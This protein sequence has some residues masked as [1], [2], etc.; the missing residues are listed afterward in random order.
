MRTVIIGGTGTLGK[1][2][3]RQLIKKSKEPV[4]IFSRDELKQKEMASEF[5]SDQVSYVLGDV[6]DRKA[7]SRVFRENDTVFHVAAIKHVDTCELNPEECI[8]TNVFGTVNV[9]D[10]AMEKHVAYV[11]FSS[12]DKAVDPINIY[13]MCKGISEKILLNRNTQGK[14][15]FS[16]FRWGNVLGSRGSVIAPFIDSLISKSTV[17][18]THA[19][20]TRFWIPIDQA[21]KFMLEQYKSAPAD[22]VLIPPIKAAPVADVAASIARILNVGDYK[23]VIIG[24]RPGEKLHEMLRSVTESKPLWSATAPKL[25][26]DELDAMIKPIVRGMR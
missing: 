8:N 10:I 3:T 5:K 23:T 1:E 6:R 12:T 24:K 11:A 7:L 2:L 25:T 17:N 9:A 21:V 13:G 22:A 26:P 4:V 18:L 19:D 14:T 16:V 15:R 20:M